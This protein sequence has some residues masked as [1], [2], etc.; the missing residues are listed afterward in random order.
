MQVVDMFLLNTHMTEND[1]N[2]C[3]TRE[4]QPSINKKLSLVHFTESARVL[5]SFRR[6]EMPPSNQRARS[7]SWGD[8]TNLQSKL[9]MRL[10]EIKN[11]RHDRKDLE[12]NQEVREATIAA[13]GERAFHLP[14]NKTWSE[15]WQ[16]YMANNH[17]F[18]GIFLSYRMS[19]IG[20]GERVIGL[21]I[22]LLIG[23][24]VTN[25]AMLW[26]TLDDDMNEK[27]FSIE[28]GED[29]EPFEVSLLLLIL[30]AGI[31][32]LHAIHDAL[33]WYLCCTNIRLG[34][35][36]W[37]FLWVGAAIM[38][39][40]I[41]TDQT[42]T[43]DPIAVLIYAGIEITVSWLVWYPLVATLLFS[44][45]LGCNSIPVLG[46][47]PRQVRLRELHLQKQKATTPMNTLASLDE[48]DAS[49][50]ARTLS[51]Y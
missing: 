39:S 32:L 40:A 30:W 22:S 45:I 28:I 29:T 12:A 11:I 33:V 15:D 24:T 6:C 35:L 44:G 13:L 9:E 2:S 34:Y 3:K 21:A 7:S 23:I 43:F 8:D 19:P 36:F 42:E 20:F 4:T 27:L 48:Y 1:F 49:T 17:P 16:Q 51:P 37:L 10:E 5:N 41:V 14:K 31:S 46:G 38:I 50:V 47:R 18:F 25:C 26:K